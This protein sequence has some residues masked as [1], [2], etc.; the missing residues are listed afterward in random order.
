MHILG[1][2]KIEIMHIFGYCSGKIENGISL[3][4]SLEERKN[5]ENK[6]D[7]AFVLKA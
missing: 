3:A 7:Y 6:K 2:S 4:Q 5:T 1:H